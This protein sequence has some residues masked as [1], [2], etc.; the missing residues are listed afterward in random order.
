MEKFRKIEEKKMKKRL[1][2]ATLNKREEEKQTA[3]LNRMEAAKT[4]GG[5]PSPAEE[6]C[7]A[8]CIFDSFGIGYWIF[9]HYIP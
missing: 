8:I 5:Q 6:M 1:N 3:E 7:T 9:F 4:V 2:L